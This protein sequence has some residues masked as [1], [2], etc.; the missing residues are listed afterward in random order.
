MENNEF[1]LSYN[2]SPKTHIFL[3]EFK[4]EN[5]KSEI[6]KVSEKM[7]KKYGIKIQNEEYYISGLIK[8]NHLFEQNQL[9]EIR[10]FSGLFSGDILT[11]RVPL[12]SL[13][14]FF[15]IKGIEYFEISENVTK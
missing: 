1:Q 6:I 8:T 7:I 9:S 2:V 11:V 12:G 10:V 5:L 3:K 4:E 15:N 14:S 13:Y